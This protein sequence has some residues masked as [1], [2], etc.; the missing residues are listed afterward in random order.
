RSIPAYGEWNRQN[1]LP[2]PALIA[3]FLSLGLLVPLAISGLPDA[4]KRNRALTLLLC[5]YAISSVI[6]S[7]LPVGVQERLLEGLPISTQILAAVGT[8]GLRNKIRLPVLRFIFI[9]V[10]ILILIPSNLIVMRN[11][12][13]KLSNRMVPQFMPLSFIDGLEVLKQ[14]A[15]PGEAI[16]S[17]E[18]AGN[19][20]IAYSTRPAVL[21]HRIGT[22]HINE[23]KAIV[24]GLL[25]INAE[26]PEAKALIRKSLARWLFWGPEERDFAAG[27]FDPKKASYLK[28]MFR[29]KMVAIYK[30]EL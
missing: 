11:D 14:F 29:N 27:R 7:K 3:I 24:A 4:L 8:I 1:I 22:A 10:L 17:M 23:K 26:T 9:P 6:C 5:C 16:F 21:S 30:I 18:L 28:E 19:F 2:S 20:A 13:M 12:L 25:E 15:K